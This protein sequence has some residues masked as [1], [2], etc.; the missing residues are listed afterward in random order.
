MELRTLEYFLAVA[1]DENIS[2]AAAA[3]HV[4]QPTLSRQLMDLEDELGKKLLIRG[5]RKIT[6]TQEGMLLRR[7]AAEILDIV[8]KTETDIR[9]SES[10]IAGDIYIGA[11]EA[12]CFKFIAKSIQSIQQD[13]P[14]IHVHISS[15]DYLNVMEQLEHGVLDYG[16]IFHDFDRSR[17]DAIDLPPVDRWGVLM[18]RDSPLSQKEYV[19]P[20]D[21]WDK[22]LLVSRQVMNDPE[23]IRAKWFGQSDKKSNIAGTFSLIYNASIMV[24]EGI[25]YALTFDNLVNTNGN[26]NLCFRPLEKAEPI[27]GHVIYNKFQIFSRASQVFLDQLRLTQTPVPPVSGAF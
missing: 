6:L 17:Y 13:Y 23:K 19:T 21:L 11:G 15:G 22:P 4:S 16:L 26:D 7:R 1:R 9:S 3:L 20:Q 25:G 18:R 2:A 12:R 10:E 8:D 24:E 27:V 5:G 14:D